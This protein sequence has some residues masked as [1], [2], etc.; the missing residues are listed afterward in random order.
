MCGAVDQ[1]WSER[2]RP[3]GVKQSLVNANESQEAV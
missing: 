3:V 1:E 2:Q